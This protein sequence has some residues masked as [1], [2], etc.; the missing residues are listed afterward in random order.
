MEKVNLMLVNEENRLFY[1]NKIQSKNL[2]KYSHL[3][4][5]NNLHFCHNRCELKLIHNVTTSTRFFQD[6][7]YERNNFA[8]KFSIHIFRDPRPFKYDNYFDFLNFFEFYQAKKTDYAVDVGRAFHR[9]L[10]Q[11][12]IEIFTTFEKF[13]DKSG[14]WLITEFTF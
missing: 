1:E 13:T 8:A 10:S 3:S 4:K 11:T 12:D 2:D 6:N 9:Y 7:V 5:S 14:K